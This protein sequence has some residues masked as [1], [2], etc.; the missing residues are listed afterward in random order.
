MS[1]TTDDA[2]WGPSTSTPIKPT[3]AKRPRL[4]EGEED[5]WE[6]STVIAEPHDSTYDPAQSMTDVSESSQI[7]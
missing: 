6:D 3:P 4:A 2:P 7:L 1:T 5:N